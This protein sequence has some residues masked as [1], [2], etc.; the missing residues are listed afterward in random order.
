MLH[1]GGLLHLGVYSEQKR[2]PITQA[3]KVLASRALRPEPEVIRAVRQEI[4]RGA[5]EIDLKNVRN[6][7]DFY[8]L[9]AC[10]DLL[11]HTHEQPLTIEDIQKAMREFGLRF[12]GFRDFQKP[13]FA[14]AYRERFPTDPS[15]TD[16]KMW[17]EY[18]S[19]LTSPIGYDFWCQ[20]R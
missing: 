4:I 19:R 14:K 13:S 2:A 17:K 18:E 6:S 16:L 7:R 8:S 11:F 20:K 12:L 5:F 9:S 10:R 15:G 1:Q 3:R